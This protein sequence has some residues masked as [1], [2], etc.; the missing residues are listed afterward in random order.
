EGPSA[1]SIGILLELPLLGSI[2]C[3][4]A[5]ATVG[6]SILVEVRAPN[7]TAY[8]NKE[9]IPIA[10][11]GVPGSSQ[12]LVWRTPGTHRIVATPQPPG[13]KLEQLLAR[14]QIA[15]AAEGPS[16]PF[17]RIRWQPGK[18]NH[19]VLSVARRAVPI[20]KGAVSTTPERA[21]VI[22]ANA[23]PVRAPQ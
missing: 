22:A 9:M 18:P 13:G 6:A 7:G 14:V 20:R 15:P 5:T 16:P 17:L 1:S 21:T 8:D 2:V 4:P 11:N 19:A 23:L 3:T 10:I 12:Y